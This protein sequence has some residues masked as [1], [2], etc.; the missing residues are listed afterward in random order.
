[1]G[2]QVTYREVVKKRAEKGP[3]HARIDIPLPDH[4]AS[5]ISFLED[6]GFEA[7]VVGGY[8]RDY[9]LKRETADVDLATNAVWTQV[10]DVAESHGARTFETGVKHGTITV[11]FPDCDPLEITTFRKEGY[12]SDSRHPDDVEFVNSVYED[13][14]RRDFTINAMAYNPA[15]GLLDPYGG[16]KDLRSKLIR[17]VGVAQERF[18]ED[19]LR[20][21]RAVRFSSTLGF[22]IEVF[23]FEA[24]MMN[25]W[26]LSNISVE[27]ITR[28]LNQTLLGDHVHDALVD[29]VE[30]LSYVLPELV[31]CKG[32]AQK[33]TYHI[34][35]VLEHTAY[36][37][38]HAAPSLLVKW[39]A[40]CHDLGKPGS[41][42]FTPDG[43]EHFYGHS[44]LSAKIAQGMLR[45]FQFSDHFINDVS[46]LVALH[47]FKNLEPTRKS[48]K[49]ML[50]KLDGREDL[51]WALCELKEVDAKAHAPIAAK[52]FDRE[53]TE[54]IFQEILAE[55][56]AFRIS[57]LAI[58]G[59]DLI[60][61]G[62]ETGP[63]IG[64]VLDCLLNAVIDGELENE[65]E[66]LLDAAE[67]YLEED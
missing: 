10:R 27:R 8:I 25:K 4:A 19:A 17:V 50:R 30:V 48:V 29:N 21:L 54:R 47:D 11:V 3:L 1:M 35:D 18:R 13:L 44:R 58:D 55:G 39:A 52:R 46:R 20:I 14:A 41:A 62:F 53:L 5:M 23:T 32:F 61:L 7:W 45:R 16:Y 43:Q 15:S 22:E 31:A 60:D 26:R 37:V 2:T 6:A 36:A 24:M 40:L 66:V 42:F 67:L 34:Y 56:E 65:H 63:Q 33:T 64:F 51:F 38:Q 12:Y 49:R 28:E 57:D 59:A 9:F